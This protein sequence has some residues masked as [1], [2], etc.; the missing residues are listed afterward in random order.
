[1]QLSRELL[2]VYTAMGFRPQNYFAPFSRFKEIEG[3][4]FDEAVESAL[5]MGRYMQAH[6]VRS[7]TSMH[8][9]LLNGRRTESEE[10]FRPLLDKAQELG[11]DVPAFRSVY[12]VMAVLNHHLRA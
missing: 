8:E 4:S 11:V 3:L 5:E 9:D 7:R 1:M 10:I 12:R 2:A 6:D